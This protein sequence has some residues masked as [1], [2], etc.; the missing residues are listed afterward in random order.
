MTIVI[1]YLAKLVAEFFRAVASGVSH[2][3]ES[4]HERVAYTASDAIYIAKQQKQA[5][6]RVQVGSIR[7]EERFGSLLAAAGTIWATHVATRDYASLWQ[8]EILRPG[9]LEVCALG[10]LVWLHAKWRRSIQFK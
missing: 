10:I 4:N 5:K 9:P 8:F 6:V 2:L 3:D 7:K 1:S